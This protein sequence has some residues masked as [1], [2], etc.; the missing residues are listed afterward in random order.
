MLTTDLGLSPKTSR[1][2][3]R[4]RFVDVAQVAALSITDLLLLQGIG[5]IAAIE[6]VRAMSKAG[7]AMSV[8]GD[9]EVPTPTGASELARA[10]YREATYAICP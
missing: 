9:T 10:V 1:C 7:Y 5:R 6:I 8:V 3:Q 4:H 2:L